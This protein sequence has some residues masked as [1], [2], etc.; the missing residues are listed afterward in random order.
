MTLASQQRTQSL[1]WG[2]HGHVKWK[3]RVAADEGPLLAALIQEGQAGHSRVEAEWRVMAGD[4]F[5][6]LHLR[7]HWQER[8]RVL[9]LV[10]DL[11]ADW[12]PATRLDGIAG[13]G[14]LVRDND[15]AERPGGAASGA[16]A[17]GPG[18]GVAPTFLPWTPPRRACA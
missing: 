6:D 8:H 13:G 18:G 9:K 14:W 11:P 5:V 17:A 1:L 4:P 10:W 2:T 3:R 16:Q 12:Q 7:V 15:G